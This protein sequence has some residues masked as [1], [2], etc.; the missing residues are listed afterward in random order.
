MLASTRRSA[1]TVLFVTDEPFLPPG[2]GSSQVYLSVTEEHR[3]QGSRVF[4]LSFYRNAMQ[5]HSA[6]TKA[7]YDEVFAGHL[8]LPGWNGGG[9]MLGK[10]GV[11][12]RE[13]RRFTSGDVFAIHPFLQTHR[14]ATARGVAAWIRQQGIER[15]YCHK[16]HALQLLQPV[17]AHLPGM[18]LTLDL[19]D[20]F[21]RKAVDYD[22]AYGELFR[23]LPL[24]VIARSHA[25]A[26]LR[27]RMRR[28]RM[29]RSR[30]TELSLLE[31]C[32]DIVIAS[33]EEA[34]RY[35][36]FPRLAGRVRHQPWTYTAT[37]DRLHDL[38][39]E[40][41][42]DIGFIGSD[43]VMNLDAVRFLRDEILPPLRGRGPPLRV[44]LAGTLARKVGPLVTDVPEI[45]VWPRLD[46]VEDFYAS[47]AIPVVPLRYGTGVS[48]K[49]L[50]AMSFGK[51][52]I[53]TTIGVRGLPAE[54]LDRI[55]IAD[56]PAAFGQ[57]IL[58]QRPKAFPIS[59]P[60][61]FA[62]QMSGP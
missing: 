32:D 33:I 24:G 44:L 60:R 2:N 57:A 62:R 38:S 27:H 31:N 5:A 10:A 39:G 1:P 11:A 35:A 18:H 53:S 41:V 15:I 42:F 14:S 36:A 16:V 30:E 59:R 6:A 56:T 43:D 13:A 17:L 22:N 34:D 52:M 12:I 58:A 4:C 48:I 20:D 45:K 23:E 3:R 47:V 55:T 46:N 51:P 54:K 21:V 25:S 28:A 49:V 40:E 61:Q 26:W 37:A 19:H 8:M 50:E 7:A 9:T 29:E